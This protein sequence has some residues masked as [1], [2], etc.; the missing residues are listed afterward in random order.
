MCLVQK[1]EK[2][3]E[4]LIEHALAVHMR[5][6]RALTAHWAGISRQPLRGGREASA[7]FYTRSKAAKLLILSVGRVISEYCF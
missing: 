4:L 3:D 6:A 5:A 2:A 7:A 1:R